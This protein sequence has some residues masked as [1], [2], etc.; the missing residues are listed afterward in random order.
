M[1]IQNDVNADYH[2]SDEGYKISYRAVVPQV[3][4]MSRLHLVVAL[5]I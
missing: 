5:A 4:C 3:Y 2:T 1:I